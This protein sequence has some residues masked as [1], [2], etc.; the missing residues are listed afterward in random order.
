MKE[1]LNNKL[2]VQS[3]AQ[4]VQKISCSALLLAV[5]IITLTIGILATTI[6]IYFNVVIN[7]AS[8]KS[9]FARDNFFLNIIFSII[10]LS[11]LYLIYKIL[12]KIN[13]KILIAIT[14]AFSLALGL[15]WVNYIGFRPIA[16][17]SMV[18]YCGEKLVE[19]D[20]PT[21][22]NP[23][24]YL[25]RNPHQLGFTV[26]IMT[27][28]RLLAK[29]SVL[30]LQILNVI[31]ATISG[32]LLYFICKEI[33]EEEMI[34]KICLL[35]ITL[36]SLYWTFFCTHVYG[37]IP[38]LMF[39]L[40]AL[41]FTLKFLNNNKKYNLAI[42][43]VSITLAYMLKSNYQIFACA[44][45]IILLLHFLQSYKKETLLGILAILICMFGFKTY[46]YHHVE[47]GTGYSLSEGVPMIAYTYMGIAEPVTLTPGW[48]TADV[49]TIY[50]QSGFNREES[51]KIASELLN[52]RLHYLLTNP[53]YTWNYFTN[54]LQTT[55]LNPT[56]QVFWCS[57]PSTM[58]DL[59][60]VY[61]HNVMSKPLINDILCGNIYKVS[62]RVM[63]VFQI[64]T[65]ISAG[66]SLLTLIKK[67]NTKYA[68][69]PLTFLGGFIFHIIWETKAIYVIQYF[70]LMLPFAAYGIYLL[71]KFI[72][73]KFTKTRE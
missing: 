10:A 23:G 44:I 32:I 67:S 5:G 54:K 14:L 63:D 27:V 12:P 6:T 4:K 21:I 72:D 22:L 8:E 64:I 68:L 65:F 2:S 48:Y 24:E 45:I 26:Y 43:A 51:A 55:W 66:I 56:F 73:N 50:N 7:F 39:G 11:L 35:L 29:N 37:N 69:L 57:T 36:F 9:M 3:K 40:A 16:D 46:V 59:D 42:V 33:F 41:L 25:N 47:K 70:Y 61:N 53:V 58:L 38:G 71:F 20:L 49:E 1:K 62:E 30:A 15:W 13:K 17:Q 19:N 34:Q 28:F 52:N 60:A 18:V 31:Y